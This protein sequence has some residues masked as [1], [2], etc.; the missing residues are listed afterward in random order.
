MDYCWL[1]ALELLI[2]G[3]LCRGYVTRG[4]IHHRDYQVIGTAYMDAYHKEREVSAFAKSDGER[5]TPF[6]EIDPTVCTYVSA[7]PD[8]CVKQMFE[9]HT[10]STAI[11]PFKSLSH[12][13]MIAD[14]TRVFDPDKE[15]ANVKN[16]RMGLNQYK[17]RIVNH[18]NMA[19]RE[20]KRKVDYYFEMLDAQLAQCDQTD[21]IID[22]LSE[23]FGLETPRV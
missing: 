8:E 20:A 1:A 5:G 15:R 10:R 14:A 17:S 9:Q 13:F 11:F 23:S 19:D 3:F 22:Q 16:L 18:A 21:K 2:K 6:I 4:R 12:S 7:Q